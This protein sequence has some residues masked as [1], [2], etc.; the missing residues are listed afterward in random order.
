MQQQ[1]EKA[2]PERQPFF[3]RPKFKLS[4][5]L[6]LVFAFIVLGQPITIEMLIELNFIF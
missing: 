1:L 3:Q 6:L 5:T 4:S 2:S